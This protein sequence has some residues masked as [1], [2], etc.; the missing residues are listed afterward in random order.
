MSQKHTWTTTLDVVCARK[1][2]LDCEGLNAAIRICL[3]RFSRLANN[4]EQDYA[5]LK[6]REM[7]CFVRNYN[8]EATIV[9][10]RSIKA[11][12]RRI[13]NVGSPTVSLE[14]AIPGA[15]FNVLHFTV[16]ILNSWHFDS[17]HCKYNWDIKFSEVPQ[18]FHIFSTKIVT[19]I[20]ILP[21]C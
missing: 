1:V 8:R 16:L 6:C 10:Y 15:V 21:V 14:I 5:K 20:N 17:F 3:K 7:P 4:H 18:L 19:D 13:K 2:H 11:P 9:L 12:W